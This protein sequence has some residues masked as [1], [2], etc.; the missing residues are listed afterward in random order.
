MAAG[1]LLRSLESFLGGLPFRGAA[2]FSISPQSLNEQLS[3]KIHDGPQR[4][5]AVSHCSTLGILQWLVK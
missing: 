2:S 4:W 5:S 1:H 3:C